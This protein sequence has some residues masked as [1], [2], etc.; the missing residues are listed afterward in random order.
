MHPE[1]R[2]EV[3]PRRHLSVRRAGVEPA[4]PEGGC[5]TGSWAR[6]CPADAYVPVVLEGLEPSIV[7]L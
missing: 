3:E 1:V 6:P 4:H 2:S 5:F 7:S